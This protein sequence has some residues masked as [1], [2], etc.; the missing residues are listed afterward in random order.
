MTFAEE[1]YNSLRGQLSLNDILL[2]CLSKMDTQARGEGVSRLGI[3][4]EPRRWII[5][6]DSSR[7]IELNQPV[8]SDTKDDR[9]S[10]IGS[11]RYFRECT[12]PAEEKEPSTQSTADEVRDEA[13]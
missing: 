1:L 9:N 4:T 6:H 5:R 2:Y 7:S 8:V 11:L 12:P 3:E 13:K 10:D